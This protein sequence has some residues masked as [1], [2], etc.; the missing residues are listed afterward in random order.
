MH[1]TNL[2]Y[3]LTEEGHE[4]EEL[5]LSSLTLRPKKEKLTKR[6]NRNFVEGRERQMRKSGDKKVAHTLNSA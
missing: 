1:L 5:T 3:C 2:F 4:R 6:K